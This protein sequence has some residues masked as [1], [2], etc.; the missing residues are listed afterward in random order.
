MLS[1]M[2]PGFAPM[3]ESAS[4]YVLS[5]L[6]KQIQDKTINMFFREYRR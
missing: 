6:L 3:G 1:S 4:E 2:Q 5:Q